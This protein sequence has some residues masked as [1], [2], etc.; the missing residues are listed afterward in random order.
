[1]APLQQFKRCM[2]IAFLRTGLIPTRCVLPASVMTA[3]DLR[4][5]SREDALVDNDTAAPKSCLSPLEIRS[6]TAAGSLLPAG[7][8]ST[9]TKT[10]FD[11]QTLWFC[12][13]EETNLRTSTQ[14]VSYYRS[15]FWTNICLL[16]LPTGGSLRQNQSK[17]G[18]LIQAGL[19]AVSAPT[20]FGERGGRCFV[21]RLCVSERLLTICSV[22]LAERMAW[23]STCR[24]EIRESFTPY[25]LQSIVFFSSARLTLMPCQAIGAEGANGGHA[26]EDG[27]RL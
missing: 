21:V 11:H 3:P 27:S 23:A 5:C 25:V 12:L 2:G 1:M 15:F 9:A 22:F 24:R 13:T 19:K 18:C 20:R 17:T 26:I 8:T 14:S 6:P 10:T 4:P 7:E 16:P